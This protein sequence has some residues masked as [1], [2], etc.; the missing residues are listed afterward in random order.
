[1]PHLRGRGAPVVDDVDFALLHIK[2]T[3]NV[4]YKVNPSV[5][6]P[7]IETW[8][9]QPPPENAAVV[10]MQPGPAGAVQVPEPDGAVNGADL[11][12][13]LIA[14]LQATRQAIAEGPVARTTPDG[15]S[16]LRERLL[17]KQVREMQ[18]QAQSMAAEI[19]NLRSEA[20]RKER[21]RLARE[22]RE[23]QRER[24]RSFSD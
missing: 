3:T 13:A 24:M 12:A 5:D 15:G 4:D 22:Q 23:R 2:G 19:T 20:E 14:E 16:S 7:R 8:T 10:V 1:M 21:E 11:L 18:A 17:D 6:T 9:V